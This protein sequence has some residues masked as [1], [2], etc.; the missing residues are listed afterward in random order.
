METCKH[1]SG[2]GFRKPAAAMRQGV[3]CRAYSFC[4]EQNG[5]F[6]TGRGYGNW[7]SS[8]IKDGYYSYKLTLSYSGWYNSSDFSYRANARSVRCIKIK[9]HHLTEKNKRIMESLK[10]GAEARSDKP[11]FSLG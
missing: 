5:D 7:W 11:S 9:R 2:A 10:N 8:S 1:G 3:E 6:Y 4:R